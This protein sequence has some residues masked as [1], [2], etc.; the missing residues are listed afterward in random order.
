MSSVL[1]ILDKGFFF[2]V[3]PL[4]TA[5]VVF[6]FFSTSRS[7][8]SLAAE[9]DSQ[10][11]SA[12]LMAATAPSTIS[13]AFSCRFSMSSTNTG[14]ACCCSRGVSAM[15]AVS[16]SRS[17][18]ADAAL[19]SSS[20]RAPRF[21]SSV[22]VS[23]SRVASIRRA[24]SSCCFKLST[25]ES[26]DSLVAL[27]SLSASMARCCAS[28]VSSNASSRRDFSAV[29]CASS[30]S[31]LSAMAVSWIFSSKACFSN[32]ASAASW[33]AWARPSFMRSSC[34]FASISVDCRRAS[35]ERTR[36]VAMTHS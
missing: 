8:V 27:N 30:L 20:I 1:F 31:F 34:T 13:S 14:M 15:D 17:A 26:S 21:S 22:R 6:F 10:A 9:S 24:I 7:L 2:G 18:M 11:S 4:S 29:T 23:L 36:S 32:S 16:C 5:F 35:R 25:L 28:S 12:P 33:T 3:S 19:V